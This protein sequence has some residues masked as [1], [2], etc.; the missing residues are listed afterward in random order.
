M[1]LSASANRLKNTTP[2]LRLVF[3]FAF[4]IPLVAVAS[5]SLYFRPFPTGGALSPQETALYG[6]PHS[7]H[8]LVSSLA[9]AYQCPE[10]ITAPTPS[11]QH[12]LACWECLCSIW[13][14]L[15]WYWC[16]QSPCQAGHIEF[17]SPGSFVPCPPEC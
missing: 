14:P 1:T 10:T 5:A 15:P 16:S 4:S 2:R 9:R 13:Q 17:C 3:R 6:Q 8:L 12:W 11:P 7:Q